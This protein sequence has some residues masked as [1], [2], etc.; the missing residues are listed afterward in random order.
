MRCAVFA[1]GNGSNFQALLDRKSAGGLTR[2]DF[3]LMIGNNSKAGAF[4]K[5]RAH[6]IPAL[7]IAPS[8]FSGEEAYAEH[9]SA[10]LNDARVEL[11]V[12]AGYMKKLPPAIV[13]QYRNRIMNIHPA[14]LPAFGGKGMYGSNVHKAVIDY[15]AKISGVTVHFV[16][17]EYDHGPIIMQKVVPVLDTDDDQTLAARVLEAEHEYYWRAVEAVA[18]GKIKIVGRRVVWDKD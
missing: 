8:H 1:S 18:E 3:V 2:A 4:D 11:I 15:G 12:L 10:A 13:G 5:A 7:H 9:L 6:G 16:D 17:D 14:L